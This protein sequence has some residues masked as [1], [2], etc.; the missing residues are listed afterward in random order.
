M[1]ED[2]PVDLTAM[3]LERLHTRAAA[4]IPDLGGLVPR[5]R[6]QPG[7]VVREDHPVDP[8]AMALEHL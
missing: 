4:R 6:R 7:R 2:H 3:A 5:R 1:R 8:T